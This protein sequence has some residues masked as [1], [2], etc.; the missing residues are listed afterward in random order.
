MNFFHFVHL[1]FIFLFCFNEVVCKNQ[2]VVTGCSNLTCVSVYDMNVGHKCD[3]RVLRF[4]HPHML[5]IVANRV[6]IA[7]VTL[8]DDKWPLYVLFY[9]F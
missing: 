7:Y 1:F 5:T 6:R 9:S 2:L 3:I 4:G 8:N